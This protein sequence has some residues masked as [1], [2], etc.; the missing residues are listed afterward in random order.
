M[1]YAFMP[2]APIAK[3]HRALV[4]ALALT[5]AGCG[6][7]PHNATLY[8]PHMPEV[9]HSSLTLD[10]PASGEGLAPAQRQRLADWF[11]AADLRYGDQLAVSDPLDRQSTRDAV[12]DV[13]AS[14]GIAQ[15]RSE[16]SPAANDRG[17]GA[18]AAGAL[19]VILTRA[20]AHVPHCP[21]WS[22]NAASNPANATSTNHGC[23]TYSNLAAMVANPD[24]LLHGATATGH[25]EL[26][27]AEKAI[28][29]WRAAAPTTPG[30][31]KDSSTRQ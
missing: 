15:I 19:R 13:A 20:H 6:G 8:S 9:S 3:R 28:A 22:G 11:T 10:L 4:A 23:A 17:A 16:P 21:D 26:M 30:T 12:A 2:L 31:A 7:V 14:F 24:D 27:S 1:P 25:T 29:A 18:V 5:L